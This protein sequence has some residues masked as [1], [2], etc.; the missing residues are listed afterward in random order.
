M[1]KRNVNLLMVVQW[2]IFMPLLLPM[3]AIAGAVE[4]IKK[5]FDQ[6]NADIFDLDL[7]SQNNEL[8]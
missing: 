8:V 6:A 1:K 4:G 5:T 3:A 2:L 7:D